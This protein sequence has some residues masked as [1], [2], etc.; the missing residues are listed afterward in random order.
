MLIDAPTQLNHTPTK[1]EFAK[2]LLQGDNFAAVDF[3]PLNFSPLN[4]SH[5]RIWYNTSYSGVIEMMHN[6]LDSAYY[7][8]KMGLDRELSLNARCMSCA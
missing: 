5:L 4:T 7:N 6:F 8:Q 3:S 2:F 1:E